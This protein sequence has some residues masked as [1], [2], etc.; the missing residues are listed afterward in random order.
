M[1][2]V[3]DDAEDVTEE[4]KIEGF[5]SLVHEGKKKLRTLEKSLM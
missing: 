3:K 2:M 5:V 1:R 4:K